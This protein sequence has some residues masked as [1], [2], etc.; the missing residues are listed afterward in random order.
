MG[1]VCCYVDD[2]LYVGEVE[3]EDLLCKLKQRFL[4]GKVEEIDFQYIG[5]YIKQRENEIMVDYL[6]FMDKLDY[7]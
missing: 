7:F 4:V 6:K 1:I 3:F 5:F 2:F